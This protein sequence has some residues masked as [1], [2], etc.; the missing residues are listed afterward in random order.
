VLE[1]PDAG[2][3]PPATDA[4]FCGDPAR[5]AHLERLTA[6]PRLAAFVGFAAQL[7]DYAVIGAGVFLGALLSALLARAIGAPG[8]AGAAVD[9]VLQ[10]VGPLVAGLT[11]FGVV[12]ALRL[13]S[14]PLRHRRSAALV[15]AWGARTYVPALAGLLVPGLGSAR[16]VA[17]LALE[18]FDD[19]RP[20]VVRLSIGIPLMDAPVPAPDE[21]TRAALLARLEAVGLARR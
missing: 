14:R 6:S 3:P 5:R 11:V 16:S 7:T 10:A 9:G 21:A 4:L 13:A 15:D 19:A 8:S 20:D 2:P 17:W 1:V 12:V 18:G